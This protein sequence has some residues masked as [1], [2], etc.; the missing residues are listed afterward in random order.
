MYND[1]KGKIAGSCG[2]SSYEGYC[3][4]DGGIINRE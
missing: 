4:C 1:N 2:N 3:D